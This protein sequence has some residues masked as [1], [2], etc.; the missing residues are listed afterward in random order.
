MVSAHHQA[1]KLASA[2][3]DWV[4]LSPA[5]LRHRCDGIDAID[6][7]GRFALYFLCVGRRQQRQHD[8]GCG[9]RPTTGFTAF[10]VL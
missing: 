3:A 2:S 7:G 9:N 8:E 5:D 1:G 6:A 10:Y 4:L